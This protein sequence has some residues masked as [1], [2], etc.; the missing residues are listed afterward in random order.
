M[1]TEIIG[2]SGTAAEGEPVRVLSP[3][4]S[5]VLRIDST[6]KALEAFTSTSGDPFT[7]Y[8]LE[9]E[10]GA[11]SGYP[12]LNAA[13]QVIVPG[14]ALTAGTMTYANAGVAVGGWNK[15]TWTNAQVVALGAVGTGEIPVCTLPAKAAVKRALVVIGTAATQ[16]ATLTVSVGTA[17]TAYINYV[18]ASNAKAAANTIYGDAAAEQG[19]SLAADVLHIPSWT[20][21]TVVNAQFIIGSGTLADVTAST[22]AVYLYVDILP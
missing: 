7:Q 20:S 21:T 8:Q 19:T 9:S 4:A 3:G 22:G 17:A 11:A 10:K 2:A 12:A 5:K 13:S 1:A 15:F 16:A 18:V 6:G 14:G